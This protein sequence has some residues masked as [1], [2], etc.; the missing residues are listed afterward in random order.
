MEVCAFT[1]EVVLLFPSKRHA[2]S[3]RRRFAS[4]SPQIRHPESA[5]VTVLA[6]QVRASGY[7]A[8]CR[9]NYAAGRVSKGEWSGGT[10]VPSAVATKPSPLGIVSAAA[11]A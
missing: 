3:P 10:I 2:R 11:L 9:E 1:S 4:S 5:G 6:I 7:N 8:F